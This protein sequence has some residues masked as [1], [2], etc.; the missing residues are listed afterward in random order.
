MQ[1]CPM[2]MLTKLHNVCCEHGHVT[3]CFTER[4]PCPNC[5]NSISWQMYST[6]KEDRR[7]LSVAS[8][9]VSR[10]SVNLL[11]SYRSLSILD[12][13]A[14]LSAA[15]ALHL[16]AVLCQTLADWPSSDASMLCH[17]H[18]L[19]HA[20]LAGHALPATLLLTCICQVLQLLLS[21]CEI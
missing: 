11:V 19:F 21:E 10:H 15:Q 13:A 9:F 20:A 3:S 2:A 8:K 6:G 12:T 17:V 5:Y 16:H 18:T 4:I 7:C 14:G 1:A